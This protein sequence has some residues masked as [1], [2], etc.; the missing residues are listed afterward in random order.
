MAQRHAPM[1]PRNP[2]TQIR[3]QLSLFLIFQRLF[4]RSAGLSARSGLIRG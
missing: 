1:M 2:L 3:K 4:L